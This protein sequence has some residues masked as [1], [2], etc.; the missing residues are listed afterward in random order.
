MT[1]MRSAGS[2][3]FAFR[4]YK[5][6]RGNRLFAG[7]SNRSVSYLLAQLKVVEGKVPV[8]IVLYIDSTYLER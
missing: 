7:H 3:Q 1:D 5:D 8:L 4:E 6:Q 2:H